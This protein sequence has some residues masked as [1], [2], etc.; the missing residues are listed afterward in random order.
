MTI[1]LEMLRVFLAVVD[2][3][4]LGGASETLGRTQSTLSMTLRQLEDDLGGRLFETDRKTRLTPLGA[5]V[6]RQARRAVDTYDQV[7]RE[8][9][10]HAR[11]EAGLVV[12]RLF[13]RW[14]DT[15]FRQCW[16]GCAGLG[17]QS[18]SIFATSIRVPWSM[19]SW[20]VRSTSDL[21]ASRSRIRPSHDQPCSPTRSSCF[22][23]PTILSPESTGQLC[24]QDLCQAPFIANGL[25]D[26]LA[27]PEARALAASA[28]LR[29]HN[30][31]SL[32][33]FVEAGQGITLLPALAAPETGNLTARP[34]ASPAPRRTLFILQRRDETLSPAADLLLRELRREAA[35]MKT[36]FLEVSGTTGAVGASSLNP[37]GHLPCSSKPLMSSS[38]FFGSLIFQ[39]PRQSWNE[40]AIF[41]RSLG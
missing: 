35:A 18:T 25:S 4:G 30:V 8:I 3:Q 1:K 14:P 22:V 38:L 20:P 11:G 9:R 37:P 32:L 34:L 39:G 21:P 27:I 12:L 28:A 26:S 17:N 15:F 13:R 16:H 2:A 10:H 24:W 29:I 36:G 31:S 23:M 19:R 7:V 5:V 41:A 33:A 6:L 40:V